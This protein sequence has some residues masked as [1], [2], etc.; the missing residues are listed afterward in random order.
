MRWLKPF[1]KV[2]ILE[3]YIDLI[4]SDISREVFNTVN[5]KVDSVQ[6]TYYAVCSVFVVTHLF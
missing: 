2:L 5:N 6:P 4:N 3:Y 1:L